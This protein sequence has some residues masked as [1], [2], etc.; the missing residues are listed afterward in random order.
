MVG[1]LVGWSIGKLI[2]RLAD[3]LIV[4]GGVDRSVGCS[5]GLLIDWSVRWS[6]GRFLSPSVGLFSLSFVS[7]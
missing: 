7:M 6:V 2:G 3:W 5:F 1:W 4:G